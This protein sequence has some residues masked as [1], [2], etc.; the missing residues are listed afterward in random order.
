[1]IWHQPSSNDHQATMSM[2]FG[3]NSKLLVIFQKLLVL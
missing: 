2:K 3:V 1:M